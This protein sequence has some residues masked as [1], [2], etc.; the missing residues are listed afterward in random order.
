[1]MRTKKRKRRK[2]KWIPNY[3][4]WRMTRK[5]RKPAEDTLIGGFRPSW[6][7]DEPKP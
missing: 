1:M 6:E 4:T 3:D 5:K 2:E 7:E